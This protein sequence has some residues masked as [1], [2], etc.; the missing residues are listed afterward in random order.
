M[1][2]ATILVVDNSVNFGRS[3][4]NLLELEGYTVLIALSSSDAKALLRQ[5]KID[6]ALFDIRLDDDGDEEDTSGIQLAK[7]IKLPIPKLFMSAYTHVDHVRELLNKDSGRS[8]GE[9]IVDK[10]KGPQSILDTIAYYLSSVQADQQIDQIH[11]F[12]EQQL[13]PLGLGKEQIDSQQIDDLEQSL[14][15]IN[16]AIRFPEAFGSLKLKITEDRLLV[17][18][19]GADF[20]YE[21]GILPTLLERKN[22]IVG[23]INKHRNGLS[24]ANPSMKYG[25]NEINE[26]GRINQD[27]KT[28]KILFLAANPKD[29]IRLRLDD[30]TRAIDLALRQAEFRSRYEIKQHW[31]VRVYELQG[32]LLRHKPDI[33]HFCGHGSLSSQIV[34]EDNLG[35]S[36]PVSSTALSQLFSVLKDNIRCVVLNAC[37]TEQQARAIAEHIDCVVG[38]SSSIT[39]PASIGFATAFYQALGYGRSVKTAFDLGCNQIELENFNEQNTPKLLALRINPGELMFK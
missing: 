33:V 39:D 15:R 11:I 30:E 25:N 35:N 5:S 20:H 3:L 7:D 31:A 10:S 27:Q 34:L 17:I 12:F 36:H 21:I 14:E 19:D 13:I 32:Y 26:N 1:K 2:K 24:K 28:I 6:L 9:D 23:R 18:G 37:Y 8:I 22:S 16:E 29:S 4:A 38:M